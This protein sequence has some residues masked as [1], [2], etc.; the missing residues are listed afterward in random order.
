MAYARASWKACARRLLAPLLFERLLRKAALRD[1]RIESG[2]SCNDFQCIGRYTFL[3]R[4]VTIGPNLKAMGLFCSVGEGALIGPNIHSTTGITTSAAFIGVE[5][6]KRAKEELNIKPVIIGNDVWV[7]AHAIILPG[8]TV[9]DGVIIGAGSVLTKDAP[10]YSVWVGNP[11]KLLRYR[12]SEANIARI[13]RMN[14]YATSAEVL[15]TWFE[16]S[17]GMDINDALDKFPL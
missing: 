12:L 11:A 4:N 8:V 9:G 3:G 10:P 7:G 17:Q 5:H 14:I 1:I 2:V 6:R 13:Q 16:R 15:F